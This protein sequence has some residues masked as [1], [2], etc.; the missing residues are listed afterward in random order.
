M[1]LPSLEKI[2]RW[3]KKILLP[4]YLVINS[5]SHEKKITFLMK[6]KMLIFTNA[7][8]EGI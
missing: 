6:K 4:C 5:A 2:M 8:P 7:L 3:R 1:L